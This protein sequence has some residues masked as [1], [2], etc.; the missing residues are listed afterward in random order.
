MI[1]KN[2]PIAASLWL[3]SLIV[4][5]M[6]DTFVLKDGTRLEGRI[7][8]EDPTNYHLEVQVTKSIKDEK[9]VAKADV[10]KI[11]RAQADLIAFEPIS[12][13]VPTPDLLTSEEYTVKIRAVEKYLADYRGGA[14]SKEA[15]EI[16]ATLKTEANEILA[17]GIKMNGKIVSPNEYR[18]NAYDI[19]ARVLETKIRSLA[20][21]ARYLEALRAFGELGRDFRNTNSYME[22]IPLI[23]QVIAT[24]TAEI[25]QQLATYDA[26]MKEREIGLQRM[27]ADQRTATER[28][29]RDET[30][31][32]EARL[33]SEKE[34]KIGWVTTDPNF[35]PSLDETLTFAKQEVTRLATVKSTP[36]SDGGKIYRD[37]LVLILG[38]GDKAAVSSMLGAAKT[39]MIAP[40]YI[41]R[42]EEAARANGLIK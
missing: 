34:S 30:A 6:A 11:E 19:D 24:Y 41:A 9:V 18:A 13:L 21:E 40:A 1:M 14:K 7:L 3:C 5:A 37:G 12:K 32:F 23:D 4:P 15:K 38:K 36:F 2:R 25:S 26:R 17:G 28:A 27:P 29:I 31:A 8:R 42:L 16:L 33:K 39:A 10:T 35:K 22:V 20:K